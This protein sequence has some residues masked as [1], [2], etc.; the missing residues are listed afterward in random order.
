MSPLEDLRKDIADG[1]AVIIVGAGISIQA[2]DREECASWTGLLRHGVRHCADVN[3]D[4]SD[5]W[6][7]IVGQEIDSG[8]LDD[9]LSAAEKVRALADL[10][11]IWEYIFQDNPEAADRMLDEFHDPFGSLARTPG[12]GH[13]RRDLTFQSVRFG[14][15]RSYLIVYRSESKPLDIVA[16]LHGKRDLK[17]ILR[18]RKPV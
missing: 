10:Q 9:L 6:L 14:P 2:T 11:E 18:K 13:I 7:G 1:R 5:T 12:M 17:K 4:L 8:D 15:V 3:A 16:V